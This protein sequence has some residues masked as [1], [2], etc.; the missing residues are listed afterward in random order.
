MNVLL[1]VTPDLPISAYVAPDTGATILNVGSFRDPEH[2]QL[3]FPDHRAAL[4]TLDALTAA[5]AAVLP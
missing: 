1:P 3:Y 2:L 4:D 5:L